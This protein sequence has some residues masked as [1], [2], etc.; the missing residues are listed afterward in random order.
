MILCFK[1]G[2]IVELRN[3]KKPSLSGIY[4]YTGFSF[5]YS[6]NE[7]TEL[8]FKIKDFKNISVILRNLKV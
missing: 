7:K 4:T 6:R 2:C 1:M 5:I 8:F 3:I